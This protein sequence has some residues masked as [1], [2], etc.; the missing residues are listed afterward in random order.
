MNNN[1][2]IARYMGFKKGSEVRTDGNFSE[3]WFAPGGNTHVYL[4]FTTDWNWLV[5]VI[6][7]IIKEALFPYLT[8]NI[9]QSL[10]MN[11][12][13]QNVVDYI[14]KKEA[15]NREKLNWVK[16]DEN[17]PWPKSKEEF[18]TR[19]DNQGGVLNL[20]SWRVSTG[21]YVSKGEYVSPA[22]LGTH[23]LI[24]P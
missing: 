21:S 18:L 9:P 11:E 7:K 22:N 3:V 12:V 19:N 23:Y 24:L 2:T 17:N 1:E 13:V 10:D 4:Y 6:V 8:F 5:P 20:V 15:E 16:V 14:K